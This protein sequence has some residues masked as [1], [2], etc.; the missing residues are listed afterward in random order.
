MFA[1]TKH[2][3]LAGIC[4][5]L[6]ASTASAAIPDSNGV[7][8]GCYNQLTG[9]AR[10]IDG[11]TCNLLE[12]A[13]TWQQTGVAGPAG[14]SVTGASL[15]V[16]DAHCPAGGVALGLGGATTY[17]CNGVAG[18]QGPQGPVG[19]Q[20]PAGPGAGVFVNFDMLHPAVPHEPNQEVRTFSS[21][22]A[23]TAAANGKCV[24]SATGF[25][26][27]EGSPAVEMYIT[28]RNDDSIVTLIGARAELNGSP[29]MQGST[30]AGIFIEAG[31]RYE[32]GVD[33][34]TYETGVSPVAVV[35]AGLTWVC[36]YY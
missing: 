5:I 9:A 22:H 29:I 19:P 21:F 7:F 16:G 17:V 8:H 6:A 12:K 1:L 33:F 4:V 26:A 2:A 27:D 23:F 3:G 18:P 24:V 36:Q 31:H 32:I 25:V 34:K 15:G 14:Q 35:Q 20:G 10:I 30:V 28:Y 11:T 13:V